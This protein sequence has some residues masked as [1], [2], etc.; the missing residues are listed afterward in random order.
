MK[1]SLQTL[2][3]LGLALVTTGLHPA[4]SQRL[5]EAVKAGNL[6]AVQKELPPT[7]KADVNTKH[8]DGYT[9]STALMAAVLSGKGDIVN[10]LIK[11][12]VDVNA[13]DLSGATALQY[14]HRT[15]SLDMVNALKA[16][17]AK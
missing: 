1:L 9:D 15:G 16:A 6:A 11:A 14:A 8:S 5:F 4:A 3:L 2:L 17:G 12:G 7:G 13:K 10:A